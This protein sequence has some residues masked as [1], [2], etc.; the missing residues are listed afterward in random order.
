M[1]ATPEPWESGDSFQS[2]AL[3]QQ[4]FESRLYVQR[5]EERIEALESLMEASLE[6][7]LN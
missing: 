1:I 2:R 5:L 6:G 3:E 7:G 4:L